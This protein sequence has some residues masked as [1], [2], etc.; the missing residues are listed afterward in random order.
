MNPLAA[1]FNNKNHNKGTA[2][3]ASK[4]SVTH[5]TVAVLVYHSSNH[6]HC[7]YCTA[8]VTINPTQ[9][10]Y[11]GMHESA[12]NTIAATTSTDNLL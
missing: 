9:I 12:Q 11:N 6:G 5:E 3:E 8:K 10:L 2:V 7:M 4:V 1:C